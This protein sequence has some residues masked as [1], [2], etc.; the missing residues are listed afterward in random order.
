[1]SL[2]FV[3]RASQRLD[4]LVGYEDGTVALWEALSPRAPLT[5]AKVH[6]EPVFGLAFDVSTAGSN[7][8][9]VT[10]L[11]TIIGI[12]FLSKS[13]HYDLRYFNPLCHMGMQL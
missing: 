8:I 3:A 6:T 1:M 13:F 11:C 4:L 2:A 9:T 12:F 5:Q 7:L 10:L